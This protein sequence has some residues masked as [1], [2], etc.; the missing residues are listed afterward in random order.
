[1][2]RIQCGLAKRAAVDGDARSQR[3][4]QVLSA[5]K[6]EIVNVAQSRNVSKMTE[7][8]NKVN[9]L[10]ERDITN[11]QLAV[12]A[13]N[14]MTKKGLNQRNISF[15][16]DYFEVPDNTK[17]EG[18]YVLVPPGADYD[19]MH[20]LVACLLDKPADECEGYSKEE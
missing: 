2:G 1:M 13:R 9:S 8:Y 5:L 14:V 11:Q 15:P 10:V 6:G 20:T 18:Q 12:I 3:Q 7:L 19:R 4:Q 17:Y 16:K